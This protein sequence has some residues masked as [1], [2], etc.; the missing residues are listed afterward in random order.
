M[1]TLSELYRKIDNLW[2]QRDC[3]NYEIMDFYSN[4]EDESLSEEQKTTINGFIDD[5]NHDISEL[6]KDIAMIQELINRF[7][8]SE[9]ETQEEETY[10]PRY[11]ILTEGDY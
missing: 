8:L 4:L 10:D 2:F 3:L 9:D 11:E 5:L 7:K 6:D 1:S